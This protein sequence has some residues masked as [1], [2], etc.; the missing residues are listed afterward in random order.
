MGANLNRHFNKVIYISNKNMKR[1]NIIR[2]MQN[3]TTMRFYN[4]FIRMSEIKKTNH[5]THG[6]YGILIYCF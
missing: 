1:L 4:T 2:E 5:I 3:K 6:E